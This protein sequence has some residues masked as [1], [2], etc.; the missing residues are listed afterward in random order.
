MSMPKVLFLG[1]NGRDT[2]RLRLAAEVRDI[3][4]ELRI[5]G[6]SDA[7]ELVAELAERPGDL[8]NLLLSHA[9]DVIHFSGDGSDR[10]GTTTTGRAAGGT[11]REM[12]PPEEHAAPILE[13]SG[14]GLLL[15]DERGAAVM[16]RPEVLTPF[17]A[18]L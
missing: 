9:P 11:S 3:R 4:R 8:Q 5:A 1:A 15:E 14:G 6:A 16:V 7:F 2:T 12:L 10:R 17:N 18:A 13:S